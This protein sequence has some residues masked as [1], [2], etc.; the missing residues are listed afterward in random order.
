MAAD[1]DVGIS[2]TSVVGT[3]EAIATVF[4]AQRK[5]IVPAT[6]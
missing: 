5:W 1:A 2:G 4:E 6:A 3:R